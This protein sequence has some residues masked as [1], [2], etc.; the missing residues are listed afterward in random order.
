MARKKKTQA[1]EGYR[2]VNE[3]A[4]VLLIALGIILGI[5]IYSSSKAMFAVWMH[6]FCFGVFGVLGYIV[7][8]L[9]GLGGVL[10]IVARKYKPRAYQV[11]MCVLGI[12]SLLAFVEL[13]YSYTF[14]SDVSYF[15]YLGQCYTKGGQLLLG[16]G[17]LGGLLA[18]PA[19][20]LLG[21][22]G[23]MILFAAIVIVAIMVLTRFSIRKAGEELGEVIAQKREAHQKKQEGKPDLRRADYLEQQSRR[24]VEREYMRA[25]EYRSPKIGKKNLFI[26]DV[27]RVEPEDDA[28]A[29]MD[30]SLCVE[31]QDM[32]SADLEETSFAQRDYHAARPS[33][34]DEFK[35]GEEE[36]GLE[37][38]DAPAVQPARQ[39]R[40]ISPASKGAQ[41]PKENKA[42]EMPKTGQSNPKH[43]YPLPPVTLLDAPNGR[44]GSGDRDEMREKAEALER[45]LREFHISAK[46]TGVSRGPAVTRYELQPAPGVKVS[47]IV[48]LTDDIALSLAAPSIRMEAPIPGKAAIGIEVPNSQRAMVT[49]R[50]MI[51]S[52]DFRNMKSKIGFA[53]GKDISGK[54]IYADLSKMPHLLIAGTT[55]SGKS[56]CVNAFILSVLFRAY[57]SEVELLMIDPKMVELEKFNG[58][59]HLRTPVITDPK[60]AAGALNWAVNEMLGRYKMFADK[61]VKDLDRYNQW[62][63]KN[64]ES[65]LPR[66]VIIIDELADLMMASAHEVEDAICRIAQ[67]G[68]A[69]G[70]HQIVA[71][72]SPRADVIT[73]LIKANFPSRIALTVSSPLESR[74][75]LDMGGA[76]KLLYNG[77]M[78]FMPVGTS[79]P[80]R[81]QG[82]YISDAE[83]EAV[84][85]YLKNGC[86]EGPNYDEQLA[87]ELEKSAQSASS[88]SGGEGS[89][90]GDELIPKAVEL[91]LE[92]E[93]IS[94][95]MLQRRLRVGYARAARL[96]DELEQCEIVSP[97]DGSK[98][99]QVLITWD[100]YHR[101]F[102]RGEE[103]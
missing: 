98:P 13:C 99:R 51:D 62:A 25:F 82:C 50:E 94:I 36:D 54:S 18:F 55:G 66:L 65:A 71:T 42:L 72:Q 78:L 61:G 29:L 12:L 80:T 34:E 15:E 69:S 9:V 88:G 41:P 85:D 68:R 43:P 45:T 53:L 2:L 73:G 22:I 7:P 49:A 40:P 48:G 47:R 103:E 11:I 58:I 90:F 8:V 101:M 83:N 26:E 59:P 86:Q 3:V 20:L 79:K 52:P 64:G 17:V 10:A 57:P 23:S 4:G 102:D 89:D 92:Y 32:Y 84:I 77:D 56:V 14:Q 37:A 87:S 67:L 19:Y 60:K 38:A 95:S 97:A 31:D 30:D 27:A 100:D 16:G 96:V 21:K 39:S 35:M 1:S 28:V 46:V 24:G 5:S 74:I 6:S 81:L 76:D 93:Q 44:Q 33:F 75:I 63:E 91:A 70:I